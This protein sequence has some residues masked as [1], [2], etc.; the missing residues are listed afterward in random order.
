[1]YGW[2]EATE[3]KTL[4]VQVVGRHLQNYAAAST[5]PRGA[6]TTLPM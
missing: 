6:L 2:Y 1:M 4:L 5:V 3:A